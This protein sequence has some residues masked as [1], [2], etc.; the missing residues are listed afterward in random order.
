VFS[1]E[2]FWPIIFYFV[3]QARFD[4]AHWDHFIEI[5]RLFAER[6]AEE[7]ESGG[8]V[9]IH[10]Y[11][12]WM[13]PAYLRRLRPDLRIAFFHH[14]AFPHPDVFNVIPWHREIVGSL[15]QCD[16]IG[17]HIPRYAEN[18][19]ETARS[20]GPARVLTRES[21]APRF[22]PFGCALGVEEYTTALEVGE[23]VVRLGAHPAGVDVPHIQAILRQDH[24][25]ERISALRTQLAGRRAVLSIERLDYVKGPLEKLRAFEQLLERRPELHGDVTL[26]SVCTPAAD[27]MQV[28][29]STQDQVDQAVGRINGRFARLGWSPIQYYRRALPFE[30][31]LAYCAIADIGWITPLRDGLNL[32]AKE[33]VA[34]QGA[35]G[36]GVLV[37]SEFAGAAVQLH[38][39]LLTNPYHP[40]DMVD[41]LDRALAMPAAE[42]RARMERMHEIVMH[43]GNR[44]WS[45][46]FLRAVGGDPPG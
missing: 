44:A 42:R 11:N 16:Y 35:D 37:L 28:Y 45:E 39:A 46:E 36:D 2:A 10:D 20:Q 26:I 25:R 33:Y 4:R 29:K 18:F 13:V 34:A 15:L 19:A 7:A 12:L 14:T 31:V 9:W 8:I 23:R 1:K 40:D 6:A 22:L 43:S 32:V 30:D 41:T 38:G 3:S 17:F 21:C 5:N 27:G 24:I